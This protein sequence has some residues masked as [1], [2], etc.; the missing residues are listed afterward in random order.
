[1]FYIF[2]SE[3]GFIHNHQTAEF[4]YDTMFKHHTVPVQLLLA[5]Q[6]K[7]WFPAHLKL[8]VVRS[9]KDY[10]YCLLFYALASEVTK[11]QYIQ[12]SSSVQFNLWWRQ[13][14]K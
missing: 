13:P 2:Y 7:K 12:S 11:T 9:D 3:N 8:S 4:D 14:K 1:M 5:G 10:Y 6:E